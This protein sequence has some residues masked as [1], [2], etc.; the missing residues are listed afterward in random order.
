MPLIC[1]LDL[2][3]VFK[4]QLRK[5]IAFLMSRKLSNKSLKK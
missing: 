5:G 1:D 3:V 4:T 2:V